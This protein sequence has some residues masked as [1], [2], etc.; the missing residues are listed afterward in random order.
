MCPWDFYF[1]NRAG[2]CKIMVDI[3]F[4][5]RYNTLMKVVLY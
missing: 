1:E 3:Y 4:Q 5:A 2:K